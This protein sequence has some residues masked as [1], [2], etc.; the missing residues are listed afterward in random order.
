MGISANFIHDNKIRN[1]LI[2]FNKLDF[3]SVCVYFRRFLPV[4]AVDG[5]NMGTD[6]IHPDENMESGRG[7]DVKS[8]HTRV[9]HPLSNFPVR[10][11]PMEQ[12]SEP[13]IK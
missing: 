4:L 6:G 5:H 11:D 2:I 3:L 13:P 7:L 12:K 9:I 1:N 10:D 8:P